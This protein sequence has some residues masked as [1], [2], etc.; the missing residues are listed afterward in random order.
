VTLRKKEEVGLRKLKLKPSAGSDVRRSVVWIASGHTKAL[1]K[2]RAS[3]FRAFRVKKVSLEKHA[4]H[5]NLLHQRFIFAPVSATRCLPVNLN[6]LIY[7]HTLL[8]YCLCLCLL[9]FAVS[10]NKFLW[11]GFEILSE[12]RENLN[13]HRMHTYIGNG[14]LKFRVLLDNTYVHIVAR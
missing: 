11:N 14:V 5:L 1:E 7:V 12:N 2:R 3:P 13:V 6:R 4:G 8:N 10:R 9:K